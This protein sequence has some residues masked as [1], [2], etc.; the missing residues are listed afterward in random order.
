[1]SARNTQSRSCPQCDKRIKGHP[2]KKFCGP[3]CKDR[4]HNTRNPRGQ[5]ILGPREIGR[6]SDGT[7]LFYA[8]FSNEE[9][10]D[11]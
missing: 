6:F 3:K 11:V 8:N 9:G 5:G 7:G 2:N 10:S 4:Y 1:M